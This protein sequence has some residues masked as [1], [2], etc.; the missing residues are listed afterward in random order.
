MRTLIANDALV[1]VACAILRAIQSAETADATAP[2]V[3]DA[4]RLD[5]KLSPLH[6]LLTVEPDVEVAADAIDMGL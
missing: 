2:R 1:A 5:Q 4:W 6:H 3:D